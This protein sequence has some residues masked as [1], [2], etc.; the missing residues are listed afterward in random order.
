MKTSVIRY[1]VADFLRQYPPF[2]SF[3]LE[4]L[5]AFSG[6]GRVVFHEDD[7]YLFRKGEEC[8]R[9]L[10]VIQQGR[11]ELLD[12][13]NRLRDVLGAG[14]ILGLSTQSAITHAHNARTATEVILYS[15][16]LDAFEALVAGY[17]EA[18]RFLTAYVSA[19]V[20]QTKALGMPTNR[21]RLLSEKE[22]NV[23]LNA[24]GPP[25]ERIS[26]RLRLMT[27]DVAEEAHAGF[28]ANR[29][30]PAAKAGLMSAD[31]LLE[32]LRRRCSALAITSDAT[33]DSPLQGIVTE[34]DL[35]IQC[36]R[37]P[38]PILREIDAA[39]TLADLAWL[40]G[41]ALE[42]ILEGLAG[43]SAVE[44]SVQA[45]GEFNAALFASVLRIAEAE[46]L[47]AGKSM[48]QSSESNACWMFFGR[49]GRTETLTPEMPHFGVVYADPAAGREQQTAAYFGMLAQKAYAK[50]QKCGLGIDSDT[51]APNPKP[52]CRTQSEWRE[53]YSGLISDPIGGAIY[54]A[55][56]LFDSRPVA[57][58]PSLHAELKDH[59]LGKLAHDDVFV[60]VL[61]NDT[62]A[63]LPPLTFFQGLVIDTDGASKQ[64]L[65]VERAALGPIVDAARVLALAQRN[66][67]AVNSVQRLQAAASAMPQYASILNDA[68]DGWRIL[69]YHDASAR[70]QKQ[71]AGA[72]IYP[73]RLGRFEQRMLKS[74]FDAVRRLLELTTSIHNISIPE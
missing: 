5:L 14:D 58:N 9:R 13:T 25:G 19:S 63:N 74:A 12:E 55:R 38:V 69:A 37:N 26:R 45:L 71:D 6:S 43:P 72:V 67:K 44:W 66:A 11:V 70:N 8:D 1:R 47:S 73:S 16:D 2:E 30:I 62:L 17:P 10:W 42:F 36:G 35:A 41:R 61:A 48:P 50:L 24:P 52:P 64:A 56:E 3:S 22:K 49:A 53:Y 29:G 20:Q 28:I 4:D 54:S 68:A 27:E 39:D 65:D 32:M 33:L 40:H 21:E 59:I 34:S 57:G 23:W 31:Y 18:A 7:V 51:S 15:F 46:M 60:P